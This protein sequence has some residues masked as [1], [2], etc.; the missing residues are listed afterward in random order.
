[1]RISD[2][3]VLCQKI[4]AR[5]R[6][7][8]ERSELR[9]LHSLSWCLNT[10]GIFK[11]VTGMQEFRVNYSLEHW[12]HSKISFR[13]PMLCKAVSIYLWLLKVYP[14][15]EERKMM[16]I[17]QTAMCNGCMLWKCRQITT[18]KIEVWRGDHM[19]SRISLSL[20]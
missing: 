1:M 16:T 4:L 5:F 9:T 7:A 12:R 8:K 15:A 11:L 10:K 14:T 13:K 18:I 17:I 6:Y 3:N 19:K 2:N 20:P